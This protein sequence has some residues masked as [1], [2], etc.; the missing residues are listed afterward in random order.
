MHLTQ[1]LHTALQLNPEHPATV[2]RGRRRTYRE[3]A[4]R[5]ARLA[6]GLRSLGLGEGER[7]AVLA[8]NSDHYQEAMLACWWAGAVLNPVNIRWSAAEI[9]YSLDDC[10]ASILI[11]DDHYLPLVEAIVAGMRQKPQLIHAGEAGTPAG[12]L[13]FEGLIA[14]SA[15]MADTF[16]GGE[17]LAVVMYTGGTTGR[18]KGVMLSHGNLL[19]GVL[20]RMAD[21][22]PVADM[23]GL[24]VAPLFHIAGLASAYGRIIT[25]ATNVFVPVFDALEVMETV[26]RERANEILL[27]PTMLQA[28]LDHPRF[29]EFDLTSL[30]RV[31]YGAAPISAALLEKALDKLPCAGFVHLYGMTENGGQVTANPPHN[32]GAGSP[33]SRSVGR[34]TLGQWVRI[35]DEQGNEVP[36]NTVGELICRGPSVMQGYWNLPEETAKTLRDGWLYT[37]DAAYMDDSGHLFVVDRVKDMIITGGENVYSVEVENVLARHP[38]IALCAV[39]GIPHDS[40]GEAVHAVVTLKPGTQASEDELRAHC[41]ESIAAY[42]CPKSVEFRESLP[43]SGAGKILKRDL[44]APF[45]QEKGS[46]VN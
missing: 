7:V 8:L 34:P 45:W 42:K 27:V 38:A 21:L 10:E 2:Y 13:S 31:L 32:H 12:M 6:A 25:G 9:A 43:L 36:R 20:M 46:A 5:V 26:Q 33:L 14:G 4:E 19:S 39:I 3:S 24:C 18:P 40:W 1:G 11:V 41:R 44:R 28:V 37:G 22:P 15:P 17:A 23:V 29:A 16:R 35:V 30:Q